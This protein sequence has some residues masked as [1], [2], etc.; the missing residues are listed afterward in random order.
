MASP[1][2]DPPSAS[3]S[4]LRGQ[5]ETSRTGDSSGNFPVGDDSP[6]AN[7]PTFAAAFAFGWQSYLQR[8]QSAVTTPPAREP[9]QFE[10]A[11]PEL[12]SNW[13]AI[14]AAN[15]QTLPWEQAREAA[16]D[17]WNRVQEALLDGS[18]KPSAH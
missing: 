11:E 10:K 13:L 14:Q 16:R 8:G 15:K 1:P 5:E 12:V 3:P 4:P 17:A 18:P 9:L 6:Y 2:H 7:D